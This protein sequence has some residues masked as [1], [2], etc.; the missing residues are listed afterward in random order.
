MS[1]SIDQ[2]GTN[3]SLIALLSKLNKSVTR[4]KILIQIVLSSPFELRTQAKLAR[5][6]VKVEVWGYMGVGKCKEA[7][8]WCSKENVKCRKMRLVSDDIL[9]TLV[10]DNWQ[11]TG[12]SSFGRSFPRS[13][14]SSEGRWPFSKAGPR[15]A[16][17][18]NGNCPKYLHYEE[19]CPVSTTCLDRLPLVCKR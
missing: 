18:K 2:L 15:S 5:S 3:S 4:D 16:L 6:D 17:M 13:E 10:G 11:C 1:P 8:I 12:S 14:I 7:S 9:V 19:M